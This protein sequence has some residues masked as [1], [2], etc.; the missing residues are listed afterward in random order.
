MAWLFE[1]NTFP[2]TGGEAIWRLKEFLVAQGWDVPRSGSGTGGAYG[3]ITGAILPADVHAPG[4]PYAGTLDL[5]NA[6]FEL[7]QPVAATLRRSFL[8]QQ[9][10]TSGHTWRIWYSS[11]G[12][13]FAGGSPSATARGTA[14]DEEG[15][16][17]TPS[18][19]TQWLP[20][21]YGYRM[22]IIAGDAAE[23]FSFFFGARLADS[24]LG[25]STV[26]SL[27]VIEESDPADVDPAVIGTLFQ[28][29]TRFAVS[30]SPIYTSFNVSQTSGCSRGWY[31]KTL[32]SANFVTYPACFFGGGIGFS[33]QA[34]PFNADYISQA[35]DNSFQDFPI[36]YWRG[37]S[38]LTTERGKKGR[39]RLY[40]ASQPRYGIFRPNAALTRMAL[41]ALSLPW[42]GATIPIF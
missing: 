10:S 32:S 29:N 5:A 8:F 41:G 2:T 6:W 26:L 19:S 37:S 3:N 27:D 40:R 39:S 28:A 15:L 12:T 38:S 16:V 24:S 21:N 20:G 14:A 42:D 23:E 4:G 17:N 35:P 34:A 25:Y 30:N 9:V 31:R 11:D 7:R 22:D 18:S 33:A 13:G 1:I 36:W